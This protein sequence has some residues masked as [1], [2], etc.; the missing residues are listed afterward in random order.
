MMKKLSKQCFCQTELGTII[1]NMDI[2]AF[3]R[4]V[5]TSD[6]SRIVITVFNRDEIRNLIVDKCHLEALRGF[7]SDYKYIT[8]IDTYVNAETLEKSLWAAISM[9]SKYGI[10]ISATGGKEDK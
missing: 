9:D 6:A 7:L 5:M 2:Q 4:C 10:R 3:Y 1:V 8:I